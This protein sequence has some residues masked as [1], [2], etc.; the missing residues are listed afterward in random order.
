MNTHSKLVVA[1]TVLHGLELT[2]LRIYFAY[3]GLLT[4]DPMTCELG[5][6]YRVHPRERYWNPARI[7]RHETGPTWRTTCSAV[8]IRFSRDPAPDT[9]A[10]S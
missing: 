3:L 6:R 4:S 1:P 10:D 5:I 7:E 2:I 8:K 9:C